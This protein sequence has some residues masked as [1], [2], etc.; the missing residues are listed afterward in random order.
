MLSGRTLIA[1]L[2]ADM[3]NDSG[4]RESVWEDGGGIGGVCM[5]GGGGVFA[6]WVEQR[7]VMAERGL[8]KVIHRERLKGCERG[9]GYLFYMEC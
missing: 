4:E 3:P 1:Q 9:N 8:V 6:S 2:N 5:V 7:V